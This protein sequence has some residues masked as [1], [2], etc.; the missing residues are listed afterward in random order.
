FQGSIVAIKALHGR[1]IK[2]TTDMTEDLNTIKELEHDNLNV[3]VGAKLDNSTGFILYKYCAKGSL[4]DVLENED[5]KLDWM[6]KMSFAIDIA[7]GMEYLHKC[8][9]K[10]N[11]NLKSNNCVIDSRW[12]VKITDFGALSTT[13]S[14]YGINEQDYYEK[15]LWTSPELLRLNKR[16]KKGSQKGDVF[17]YSIILYEI[18]H[19]CTPYFYNNEATKDVIFKVRKHTDPPY[20]P[21]IPTDHGLV[22]D[23]LTLMVSCWDEDPQLRPDFRSIRKLLIDLNGGRKM[24]IMD[25]MIQLLEAYSGNL[26]KLVAERTEEV[27]QEKAKTERLLYQML[28]QPVADQLKLGN[29]VIP[30][31]FEE[32]SI[33]F[34]D[35]VGFTTIASISEP[36]QVVDLLNDLYTTFDGII[37]KHDVYKVETIG[38]AYMCVSGVPN[39]NGKRHSAE[40]ANMALDLISAVHNFRIRHLPDEKLLLRAGLHTGSC[41]AGVV[42]QIMPRYCLF[43]DNVNMAS[44]M[45]SMGK[46]S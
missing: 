7:K 17:S 16:P 24:N 32:V 10:S 28:P 8:P 11:G 29:P 36:L 4:H 9:L 25:N 31:S 42:G 15:L 12:V 43:G 33:F 6:F 19:R 3:F 5:I 40:I 1:S 35:I 18:F 34:S 46:G 39:P 14:I 22:E 23:A 21:V 30:E 13:D 38:D 41:A 45:E 27:A 37:A 20:R 26:E 2:L 44:R